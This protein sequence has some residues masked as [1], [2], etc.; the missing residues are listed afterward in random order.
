MN[1][2]A[3]HRMVDGLGLG[4]RRLGLFR[5]ALGAGDLCRCW[6]GGLRNLVCSLVDL[7]CDLLL[8]FVVWIR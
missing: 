8:D 4:G 5:G 1:N 6:L 2:K 7:L 3:S